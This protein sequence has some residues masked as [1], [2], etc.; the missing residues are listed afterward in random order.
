ME[1]ND[2]T[3]KNWWILISLQIT[4][5]FNANFECIFSYIEVEDDSSDAQIF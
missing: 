5:I 3:I 2:I 4:V 1:V